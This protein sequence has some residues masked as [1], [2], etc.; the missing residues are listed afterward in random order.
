MFP[1]LRGLFYKHSSCYGVAKLMSTCREGS[2]RPLG[3]I[4]LLLSNLVIIHSD[5][6]IEPA[7]SFLFEQREHDCQVHFF[8]DF[9][10]HFALPFDIK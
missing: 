3:T 6:M 7:H 4:K 10:S 2:L 5:K 1:R 8:R 9:I